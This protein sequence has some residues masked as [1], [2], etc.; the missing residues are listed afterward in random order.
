[1]YKLSCDPRASCTGCD[2]AAIWNVALAEPLSTHFTHFTHRHRQPISPTYRVATHFTHFTH[3]H[4]Q[5]ISL[6]YRASPLR[7]SVSLLRSSWYCPWDFAVRGNWV[8]SIWN[9]DFLTHT[10]IMKLSNLLFLFSWV[11]FRSFRPICLAR[12]AGMGGLKNWSF[13]KVR[14]KELKIF[15]IL[16]TLS[17]I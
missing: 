10:N 14:S 15:N 6:T 9:G 13:A 4:R 2:R 1:M 8:S 17:Q 12:S 16:K 11:N 3:R 5:P 7:G